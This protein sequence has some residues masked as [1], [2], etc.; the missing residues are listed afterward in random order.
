MAGLA[1]PQRSEKSTAASSAWRGRAAL[2]A[3]AII[4]YANS[5][6]LGLVQDSKVI[7][8]QDA[9]LRAVSAENLKLILTKNYWYPKAGDGLYRPVTTLSL[10]ANYSVLGNGEKAGGYHV[11]NVLL[12][13]INVLLL[14]ELALLAFRR[15]GP[16][17]ATAALWAV[18]PIGPEAVTSI[19][20]RADLLAAMAVLGSLVLYAKKR[21]P[22]AAVSLFAVATLGVF[23]KENAAILLGLMVLWEVCFGEGAAAVRQRW[24]EYA[25]VA[26]SLV[27]LAV[28]RYAV[29]NGLPVAQPVYVDNPLR[30]ADFLTGRWTAIKVLG[31]DLR[32]VLLPLGLSADRSFDEIA[33]SGPGD[34]WAW[35]SAGAILAIG[36]WALMRFRQD[37]LPLWAAGFFGMALLPT[38]NLIVPIGATVAERFL[39]LPS[40]AFAMAV[41][42]LLYRVASGRFA[43]AALIV[44]LVAYAGRTMVR[45]ADWKDDYT[46][47]TADVATTPR[48]FR[49]HDLLAK[50][51]YERGDIDGAIREQEK[52]WEILKDLPPEKSS[53]FPPAF[54]GIYYSVKGD[55]AAD[56]AKRGWYEKSIV[57]L[58]KAAGISRVQE[59][60]YDEE[61]QARGRPK[62]SRAAFA[63][64][65]LNLAKDYLNLGNLPAAVEALRYGRGINPPSS[66]SY[67]GLVL[68]YSSMGDLSMAAATLQAKAQLDG[69]QPATMAALHDL[70]Q[71]VPDGACAFSGTQLNGGCPRVKADLCRGLQELSEAFREGRVEATAGEFQNKAVQFGCK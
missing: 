52:S 47:G 5:F 54:L 13:G 20:G 50:A 68:A 43:R 8:T 38:S 44:L 64:I 45:N 1:R 36:G 60:L 53:E 51:L 62:A 9:R 18:H 57:V 7:V 33:L 61:Q 27:V 26:A 28:V 10:L 31:L 30:G 11:V 56:A 65:Y 24:M 39:Y 12:H 29:L 49:L 69:F 70:Y 63:Q 67:D 14:Y 23:A 34:L 32:L 22:G 40:A 46:L 66:E 59:R 19:V 3:L 21:G 2:L 42:A 48:S 35:L 4:A 37:K 15:A 55:S 17:L 41:G 6:G 16:A 58:Q 25:A 71:R